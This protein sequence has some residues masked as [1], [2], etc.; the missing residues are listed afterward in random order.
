MNSYKKLCT[1]FYDIDKLNAPTEALSFY[2]RYA[3]QTNG[4]I[5]EPMCGSGRF[6]LPLLEKGFPIDGVDASGDMLQA[7]REKGQ[8][9]G[10]TPVLFEQ[11]LDRLELPRRYQLVII[12]AGSFCLLIDPAQA[13]E[14]LRRLHEIMVPG[15]YFVLEIERLMPLPPQN[16]PWEGRW[17][18]RQDGS[19]IVLSQLSHFNAVERVSHSIHRYDLIKDGRSLETEWEEFDVRFYEPDEFSTLLE[20]A[21]FRSIKYFKPYGQTELDDKDESLVFECIRP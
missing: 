13:K 16:E 9:R 7:C 6:L 4:A 2:L 5:L 17:V 11:F 20:A 19:K 15:A 8:R 12:P 18:N 14:S 10:L 1:E 21:G 3:E